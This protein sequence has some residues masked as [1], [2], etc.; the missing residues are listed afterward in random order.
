LAGCDG[1]AASPLPDASSNLPE[2]VIAKDTMFI[3]IAGQ[4]VVFAVPPYQSW[5]PTP[6]IDETTALGLNSHADLFVGEDQPAGQIV[7]LAPPYTGSPKQV[8]TLSYGIGIAVDKHNNVWV[9]ENDKV[10]EYSPPSYQLANTLK[11]PHQQLNYPQL[12]APL[13]SGQLA[14]GRIENSPSKGSLPGAIDIFTQKGAHHFVR[15]SIKAVPYPEAMVV[16]R[17]G[18]MIVAECSRCVSAGQT[19]NSLLMI[20]PP[21]KSVTKVL[22]QLP[23]VTL[24]GMAVAPNGDL[25]V[26]ENSAIVMYRPPFTH[27]HP[28]PQTAGAFALHV[29]DAGDLI[30]SVGSSIELLKSPYTGKAQLIFTASGTPEQIITAP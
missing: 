21:Y 3:A 10:Q 19:N 17:S 5:S 12:V 16:D 23:N 25:A 18:D 13:P 8:G 20:S 11:H 9:I 22:Q 7:E 6:P 27:G 14:V 29:N 15:Q 1:R 28:L 4:G 30:Y 2:S 26:N 24:E